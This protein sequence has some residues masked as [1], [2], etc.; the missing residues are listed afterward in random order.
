MKTFLGDNILN[1]LRG[2]LS[3]IK[4]LKTCF[5]NIQKFQGWEFANLLMLI[6]SFADFAQIKWATVSDSFRSLKTNE[7]QW[8]NRSGR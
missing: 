8:A 2:A 7:P 3:K 6:C 5:E 1:T 4:K